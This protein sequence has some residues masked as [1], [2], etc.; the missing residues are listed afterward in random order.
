MTILFSQSTKI[1]P[2]FHLEI[3][4]PGLAISWTS[5]PTR[6]W[7]LVAHPDAVARTCLRPTGKE[8]ERGREASSQG[9][10]G[11]LARHRYTA[12]PTTAA[13]TTTARIA[14]RPTLAQS[15]PGGGAGPWNQW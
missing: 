2:P 5:P 12:M 15:A 14:A 6:T 3:T 1:R 4:P 9:P 11:A 8:R 13:P 10:L 7:D